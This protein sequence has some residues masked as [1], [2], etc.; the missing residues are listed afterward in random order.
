VPLLCDSILGSSFITLV[1]LRH[2]VIIINSEEKY[3]NAHHST[4]Y[5]RYGDLLAV[6]QV[7]ISCKMICKPVLM[8][9]QCES[10][11]RI[12]SPE[13]N[14]DQQI[15]SCERKRDVYVLP[16]QASSCIRDTVGKFPD[17]YFCNCLGERR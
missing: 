3:V 6:H 13:D 4:V 12:T 7:D 2:L 10:S 5:S 1:A 16:V 17:R 9:Q 15:L 8:C 14:V 11:D